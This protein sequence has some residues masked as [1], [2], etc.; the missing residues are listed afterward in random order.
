MAKKKRESAR[1]KLK[2][3]CGNEFST[4]SSNRTV[5]HT[6][7][8][9]CKRRTIFNRPKPRPDAEKPKEEEAPKEEE[10]ADES[11]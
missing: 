6:C 7:K 4:Y 5:C 8:P 2:C 3:R 10:K 11:S 9:K 1:R